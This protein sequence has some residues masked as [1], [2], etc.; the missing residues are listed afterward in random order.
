[1][2]HAGAAIR[3]RD[4]LEALN[5]MAVSRMTH[6][7]YQRVQLFLQH[8]QAVWL[9]TACLSVE[10]AMYL[11]VPYLHVVPRSVDESPASESVE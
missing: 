1:M 8:I 5:A 2:T 10:G 11:G 9:G 3:R 6:E 4:R 7:P